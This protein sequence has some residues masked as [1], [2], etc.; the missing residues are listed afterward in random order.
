[1][2]A[3]FDTL[4]D[5]AI[6]SGLL[7]LLGLLWVGGGGQQADAS[8]VQGLD[9]FLRGETEVEADDLGTFLQQHL[10]HCRL[11]QK[12]RVAD[13]QRRRWCQA[14][15]IEQWLQVCQPGCGPGGIRL[16][17]CVTEEV[18][19]ERSGGQRAGLLDHC[20]GL[21][22]TARTY[23]QRAQCTGVGY[24]CGQRRGSHPGHRCLDQRELDAQTC[25]QGGR[26]GHGFSSVLG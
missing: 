2:A 19:I 17:R 8:V 7:Y 5:N 15:I 18:D 24:R 16:R 22:D 13:L 23:A 26:A 12:A 25:K 4:G 14:K 1:M 21:V 3:S 6:Y 9:P 20:P 11:L 10:Q